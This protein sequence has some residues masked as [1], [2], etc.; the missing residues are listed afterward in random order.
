MKRLGKGFGTTPTPKAH[1]DSQAVVDAQDATRRI[2]AERIYAQGVGRHA[3][4]NTHIFATD[5]LLWRKNILLIMHVGG[6]VDRH[7]RRDG[8][9][10]GRRHKKDVLHV[11]IVKRVDFYLDPSARG[12]GQ[13]FGDKG[14][15]RLSRLV[16][17]GITGCYQVVEFPAREYFLFQS[18][19]RQLEFQRQ[20]IG[21]LLQNLEGRGGKPGCSGN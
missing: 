11:Y 7:L 13:Q 4:Q 3:A 21:P 19:R 17:A 1:L 6:L 16:Q 20:P 9:R 12:H 14:Q 5:N 8:G 2:V 15:R 18:G 10:M